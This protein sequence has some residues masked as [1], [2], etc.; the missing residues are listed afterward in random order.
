MNYDNFTPEHW[1]SIT[2]LSNPQANVMLT[3]ISSAA[4]DHLLPLTNIVDIKV[5]KPSSSARVVSL[6]SII[7]SDNQVLAGILQAVEG[8][9]AWSPQLNNINT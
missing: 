9:L 4:T 7:V 3:F 6:L 2:L 8:Y 1:F 5:T